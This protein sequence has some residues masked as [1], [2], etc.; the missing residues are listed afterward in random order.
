MMERL[1]FLT[2]WVSHVMECVSTVSFSFLVNGEVCGSLKPRLGLRQGGPLSSYLFLVC[3]E[4]LSG[5][6]HETVHKGELSGLKYGRT[7]PVISHLLFT[8]DSLF[9]TKAK[10]D[11]CI[12]IRRTLDD[13][14]DAY[15]QLVNFGK[16]VMSVSKA[17]SSIKGDRLANIIGVKR[18]L[19]HESSR[20]DNSLTWLYTSNGEYSVKSG[21]N[22]GMVQLISHNSQF[23]YG[24]IEALG[25]YLTAGPMSS[26]SALIPFCAFELFGYKQVI[27]APMGQVSLERIGASSSNFKVRLLCVL[28]PYSLVVVASPS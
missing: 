11:D 10:D 7:W 9:F 16:S 22:L 3:D 8:D 12:V 20:V 19:C 6:L 4:G 13:C 21:Y 17:I 15:R 2:R 18:V 25:A 14:F 1:G 28:V 27:G 23:V 24:T 5:L 26:C